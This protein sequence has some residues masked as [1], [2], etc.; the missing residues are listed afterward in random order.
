M[1]RQMRIETDDS[2]H[3]SGTGRHPFPPMSSP[4]S[5][6]TARRRRGLL[7]T[8]AGCRSSTAA[9]L[10]LL[11]AL[12][13]MRKAIT[14]PDHEKDAFAGAIRAL[15]GPARGAVAITDGD[16]IIYAP[17]PEVTSTAIP[18]PPAPAPTA[19][20][21]TLTPEWVPTT[22]KKERT[23]KSRSRAESIRDEIESLVWCAG[24]SPCPSPFVGVNLAGWLVLE[25]TLVPSLLG[26]ASD[27]WSFI[28]EL[29]GPASSKAIDSMDQ[30][31]KSFVTESD[32]EEL[33]NFGVSHCR[34]P[35][36]YWLLDYDVADGFV[37]GGERYLF[38]LLAWLKKR[39]MKAVLELHAMPGAQTMNEGSTG[40]AMKTAEFFLNAVLHTRGRNVM[41]KMAN[42]VVEMNRNTLTSDVIVG[43]GLLN[44]PNWDFWDTSPGIK[45]L[46][47]DMVPRIRRILAKEKTAILLSFTGPAMRSEGVEWLT[48]TRQKQMSD[49]TSVFYDAHI[50]HAYGDN[51]APGRSWRKD[52]D[53]CKTCCRDGPL[54]EP[55]VK[56]SLP[57]VV[58]EYS[59]DTGFEEASKETAV[60][61]FRNQRSLWAGTDGIFGS[62]FWNFKRLADES[63]GIMTQHM[64]LLDILH[65]GVEAWDPKQNDPE[66]VSLCPGQDLKRC[67]AV[68]LGNV[69]WTD[70]CH[71]QN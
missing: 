32:L 13:V 5:P 4:S 44:E 55:L 25:R 71:W 39:N 66:I 70:E 21:A 23:P 53:S 28:H 9:C 7:P 57:I 20:P 38:R 46:Y 43:L 69:L 34:I 29:G 61:Y 63:S 45:E 35:V 51:N 17:L 8:R 11:G 54:L 48:S 59:V 47:E 40:R 68:Y 58:G 56:A 33:R 42:L 65:A 49:Y 27:E 12:V 60:A 3:H 67:P 6:V 18:H 16:H 26:N 50:F 41:V 19:P 15:P 64:S 22:S 2:D 10:S 36:G 31:W 30:H 24:Q 1:N 37:D 52:V 14:L 62:F